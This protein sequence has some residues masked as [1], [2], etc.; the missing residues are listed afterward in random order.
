MIADLRGDHGRAADLYE[1]LLQLDGEARLLGL[2]LRAWSP[3]TTDASTIAPALDAIERIPEDEVFQARLCAKLVSAAFGHRWDELIPELLRRAI[4]WAPEQSVLSTWLQVERYN[5]LGGNWPRQWH[6][7]PDELTGYEWIRE[8]A[9]GATAKTLATQLTARVQSPWTITIGAGTTETDDVITALVQAEWAG[10]VWLRREISQQL[11]AHLLLDD[12]ESAERTASGV[13]LWA[14][15]S[16]GV[17]NL[18][19]LVALAEP[20]FD[21]SSAD[22]IIQDLDRGPP[23]RQRTD[24]ILIEAAAALWDVVSDETM[25][26]LLERL[27]LEEFWFS[28][29][30]GSGQRSVPRRIEDPGRVGA[31]IR[32]T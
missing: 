6:S 9:A 31:A 21:E 25:A 8:V 29:C 16:S 14:L 32:S 17:R 22:L 2:F 12:A 30:D 24:A 13:A 10:A 23:L 26:Y 5:L 3:G 15:N 27:P 11:A 19:G 1:R 4:D 20:R 28:G 18:D 7:G